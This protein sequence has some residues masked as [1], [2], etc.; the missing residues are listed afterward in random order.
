MKKIYSNVSRVFDFG[1]I[2]VYPKMIFKELLETNKNIHYKKWN[3]INN[4][5]FDI[6]YDYI[7]IDQLYYKIDLSFVDNHLKMLNI[8]FYNKSEVCEIGNN[9]WNYFNEM[10]QNRLIERY[11]K[12]LTDESVS[13]NECF[14]VKVYVRLHDV[15]PKICIE[16]L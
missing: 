1:L 2:K 3:Y 14:V 15:V 10:N 11:N 13:N 6:H 8:C 12:W 4:R 7:C 5:G 9:G 16:Y